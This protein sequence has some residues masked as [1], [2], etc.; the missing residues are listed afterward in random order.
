MWFPLSLVINI[1]H[2]FYQWLS[3]QLQFINE[4]LLLLSPKALKYKNTNSVWPEP[5]VIINVSVSSLAHS[6]EYL[7]FGSTD[8]I[9]VFYF[10]N[11]GI[12]FRCQNPKVHRCNKH[13]SSFRSGQNRL[14]RF[15]SMTSDQWHGQYEEKQFWHPELIIINK[16]KSWVRVWNKTEKVWFSHRWTLQ[17][18]SPAPQ[19]CFNFGSSATITKLMVTFIRNKLM[20]MHGEK[21]LMIPLCHKTI[22]DKTNKSCFTQLKCKQL[23]WIHLCIDT[24]KS[25]HSLAISP[26]Y[27]GY[28]LSIIAQIICHWEGNNIL[29]HILLP[30]DKNIWMSPGD[31]FYSESPMRKLQW[32]KLGQFW[33]KSNVLHWLC[34]TVGPAHNN[35]L[36]TCCGRDLT[37]G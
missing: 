23:L 15:M 32:G 36:H 14:W 2:C 17:S 28:I 7:C 1:I 37:L 8:N 34:I 33:S 12:D 10:F 11:S 9:N 31:P 26:R 19:C 25:E 18:F 3:V 35:G 5:D 29:C 24:I 21:Y 30:G 22:P 4:I 27:N 16:H 20:C 6:F 13:H